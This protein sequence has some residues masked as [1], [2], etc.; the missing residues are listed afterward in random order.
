ML[1][2]FKGKPKEKDFTEREVSREVFYIPII[3]LGYRSGRGSSV[4]YYTCRN[5]GAEDTSGKI[6]QAYSKITIETIP[7]ENV[8]GKDVKRTNH[9]I[10]KALEPTNFKCL[11]CKLENTELGRIAKVSCSDV[12]YQD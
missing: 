3:E 10:K 8:F 1:S 12:G 4:R 11:D 5:C 6:S 9:T 7:N 2:L